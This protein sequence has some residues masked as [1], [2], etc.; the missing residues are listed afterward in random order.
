VI[1]TLKTPGQKAV[2]S[3]PRFESALDIAKKNLKR[4][5]DAGVKV[6]FGTDTGPP[7]RFPGFFEH[8]EMQLMAE[9]GLTPTQIIQTATRNSAEFLGAKDLGTLE[10]GK[11]ADLIVLTKNPLDDIRNTRT[12]ESVMIAGRKVN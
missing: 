2:P 9:A 3:D 1:A 12:I 5:Y 11:W 7:G 8:L 6:G 4:I 10:T